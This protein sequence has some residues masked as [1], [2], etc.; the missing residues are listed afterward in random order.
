MDFSVEVIP[1][2]A[3]LNAA[4]SLVG[5]PLMH[6]FAAISLSDHLTPW[7]VI[8]KRLT[9][10]AA[11]DFVLAILQST[12]QDPTPFARKGPKDPSRTSLTEDPGRPRPVRQSAGEWTCLTTLADTPPG[13]GRYAVNRFS[14]ETARHLRLARVDD[15]PARLPP[16]V[17]QFAVL[18]ERRSLWCKLGSLLIWMVCPACPQPVSC[19]R[20]DRA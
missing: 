18:S 20:F 5:A 3:A 4:A 13:R 14:W 8:E 12:E 9:A 10:A 1:G 19:G 2:V 6:D 16:E 11:A 17:F 15:H 7:E